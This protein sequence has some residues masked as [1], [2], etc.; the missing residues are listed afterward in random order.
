MIAVVLPLPNCFFFSA[1]RLDNPSPQ[2]LRDLPR[3]RTIWG[4]LI[5]PARYLPLLSRPFTSLPFSLAMAF[6]CG[7]LPSVS[8]VFGGYSEIGYHQTSP[9]LSAPLSQID[10][11]YPMHNQASDFFTPHVNPGT[12]HGK[13]IEC[14]NM[15]LGYEVGVRELGGVVQYCRLTPVGFLQ[16][17]NSRVL[18]IPG[19]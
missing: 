11:T 14:I 1:H 10:P 12:S 6:L 19:L 7:A 2:Q 5:L 9:P 8:F 15:T 17:A 18:Q 13:H 16:R 4:F 3:N